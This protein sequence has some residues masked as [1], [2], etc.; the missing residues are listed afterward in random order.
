MLEN[1]KKVAVFVFAFAAFM[2][3]QS[4]VEKVVMYVADYLTTSLSRSSRCAD[5]GRGR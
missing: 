2:F 1:I 4:D 5:I 3:M